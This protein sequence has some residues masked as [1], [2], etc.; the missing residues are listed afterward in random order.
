MGGDKTL[1][2]L[3]GNVQREQMDGRAALITVKRRVVAPS[4][5]VQPSATS[6]DARRRDR[7]SRKRGDCG[8]RP[9]REGGR[10]IHAQSLSTDRITTGRACSSAAE[11]LWIPAYVAG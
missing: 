11:F 3:L 7:A 4:A 9:V 1:L 8:Y 10:A 5:F 6:L 2:H